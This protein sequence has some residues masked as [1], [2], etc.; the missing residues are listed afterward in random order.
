MWKRTQLPG[1]TTDQDQPTR[2][3]P[4]AAHAHIRHRIRTGVHGPKRRRAVPVEKFG[5]MPL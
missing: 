3:D 5:I 1:T 4:A 2:P